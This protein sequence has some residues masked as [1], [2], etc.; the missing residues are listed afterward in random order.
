MNK[1]SVGDEVVVMNHRD[2]PESVRKV[3][4][5]ENGYPLTEGDHI[6]FVRWSKKGRGIKGRA[7][8][9][10][11]IL[12]VTPD[13][14]RAVRDREDRR[15]LRARL[16]AWDLIDVIQRMPIE[17][18]RTIMAIL[19]KAEKLNGMAEPPPSGIWEADE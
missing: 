19:D 18:V 8:E 11:Y 13:L 10:E 15:S 3:V 5:V 2:E 14:L 6:I 7:N 16:T 12:P 1:W 17:D 9:Y 4:L